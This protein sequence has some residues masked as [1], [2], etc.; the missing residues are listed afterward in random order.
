L[1]D[2]AGQEVSTITRNGGSYLLN[3]PGA[4]PVVVEPGQSVYFGLGW[5][6]VNIDPT[7]G[8]MDTRDCTLIASVAVSTPGADASLSTAAPLSSPFCP[9]EGGSVTAI[10]AADSFSIA[11]PVKTT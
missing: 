4:H 3:D 9:R 5:L 10:A 8:S 1:Y 11:T 7:A 6:D 2:S